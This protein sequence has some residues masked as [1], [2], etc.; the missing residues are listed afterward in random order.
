[1]LDKFAPTQYSLKKNPTYWQ[2]S[3]IVPS[4][5][6]LPAQSTNQNTNQLDVTSGKFDWSYNFLPNVQQTYVSRDSAH[7]KY[8]FPPGGTIGLYLNL[9]KAPYNDVNFRKGISLALDRHTI[10][11][12]AV[13]GYMDAAS[14]S[15]LILPNEKK[16]LDPSIPSQGV[17]QQNTSGAQA[18]FAQ[19]G[20]TMQG[21]QLVKRVGLVDRV[22]E[23]V[24]VGGEVARDA[25]EDRGVHVVHL[26][27][28]VLA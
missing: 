11:V 23:R 18:A 5:V 27:V 14:L 1:M 21:G 4:E 28:V 10:A 8:W 17:V 22:E 24:V 16:W 20:Y 2:A 12:K 25:L 19:A 3:K 26:V 6:V 13:N 7:N 15:G 9:T